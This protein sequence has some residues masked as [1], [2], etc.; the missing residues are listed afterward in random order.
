MIYGKPK[1]HK[2]GIPLRPIVS[3]IGSPTHVL[4][5]F[6]A[7]KLQPFTGQT[8]SFIKYSSHF[9]QKTRNFHLDEPHIM[10]I[11]DVVCIFTKI[12]ISESLALIFNLVNPKTLNVIDICL[13]STFFTS[14]GVFYE[15]IEGIAMGYSLSPAEDNI[16]MEHERA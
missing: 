5:H 1:I 16:F 7:K 3:T 14:K 13:S 6:L 10:V 8:F 11:F 15:Q 12:S 9:I 2:N 4:T